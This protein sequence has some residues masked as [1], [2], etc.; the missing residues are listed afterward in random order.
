MNRMKELNISRFRHLHNLMHIR[1][2]EKLTVIAGGN[3]TGKSSLL[4]LIGHVFSYRE[5]GKVIMNPFSKKPLETQFSEVFRFSPYHDYEPEYSYSLVFNDGTSRNGVSRFVVKNN[6]FRI[7][8]GTREKGRGKVRCPVIYLSL[9]RLIPLAQESED[10]IKTLANELGDEEA[11]LY[12]EWHNSILVLDDNV[13]PRHIK[14]RNKELYYPV[15]DKYDELGSSAGQDNLAQIILALL[16]F[17][18][19]KEELKDNYPGGILLIDE[20]ETTLYPAAQH[21]LMHRLLR[22]AGDYDLQIVFTTHSTDTIR[23]MLNPREQTFYRSTEI[24]Y[25]YKPKGAIEVCQEKSEL[26]GIVADLEHSVREKAGKDRVNVYLEDEEARLFFKGIVKSELRSELAISKCNSGAE[27]YGTLLENK[28]PEFKRS[29]I[30]LDGDKSTSSRLK[31]NRNVLFLPGSE[32]PE[33]MVHDYLVGLPDDDEF[34]ETKLGGYNK[35]VFLRRKPGNTSDGRTMK[36][37]FGNEKTNWGNGCRRLM[38]RW[39]KDNERAVSEF[40]ERLKSRTE[41]LK[42]V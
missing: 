19:M 31:R 12:K 10:S 3:G 42:T 8:V 14:S 38:L 26:P 4:G 35:Q 24:V 20:I 2:G 30:V 37:W 11:R 13:A 9:K 7:D 40:N 5:G 15:C 27:F 34:W 28:F 18:R 41:R 29:L 1:I 39:G 6:R 21:Q 16:S 22:A 25:L 17:R 23:Y 32:R 36:Q 33:N